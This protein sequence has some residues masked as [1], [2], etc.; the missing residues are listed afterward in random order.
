MNILYL[1]GLM[2]SLNPEKRQIV[3]KY[4]KA[5]APSIPYQTNKECISW[6]YHNYKDKN[7]EVVIGSSLGGFSGYYLSRLL[8]VPALLFNPAL[9]NRSVTQNIPEITNIHREPMHIILGAKDDVVNPKST[10]QF[11]AEHF[12]STQNYQ[13]QTLPELAHRIPL[14]TFKTSVDQFFTTLLTNNIP[15]KH[16]FLDDIRSADMVYEPIFSNSFDVVR[17][18]EEFVKYITTFGLP[19]FISFDNDLGLDTNGE[20]ALDGYA[21]TKWLIYESGLDLSNLQ[22]AVHSANPVAAEQIKGLLNNYIKFLNKK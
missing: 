19:D 12:P 3:E 2:G 10:L 14:Q 15:K 13:I 17:S 5:Y 8:Q 11:I 6:L 7:I 20:V 18:Y 9:A 1:H 22:F 21:A 16:L 4:G